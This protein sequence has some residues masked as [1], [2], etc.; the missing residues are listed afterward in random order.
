MSQYQLAYSRIIEAVQ[1][2]ENTAAVI[3]GILN[4]R[5]STWGAELTSGAL[6][7]LLYLYE[8]G[9]QAGLKA[10]SN[11]KG[12][13]TFLKSGP[14]SMALDM[15][16]AINGGNIK[17]LESR[18]SALCGVVTYWSRTYSYKTATPK[19]RA[20][21]KPL[22]VEIVSTPATTAVQTVDRD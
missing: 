16:Q 7:S 20:E 4:T 11:D 12:L 10:Q 21:D 18:V 2:G 13:D 5:S 19:A 3:T 15:S 22:R 8:L 14:A 6:S 17:L 9:R 1:R